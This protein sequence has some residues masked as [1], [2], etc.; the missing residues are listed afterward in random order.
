MRKILLV[1]VTVLS[2]GCG[3]SAVAPSSPVGS[4]IVSADLQPT[5]LERFTKAFQKAI[6]RA[7]GVPEVDGASMPNTAK[8]VVI[9]ATVPQVFRPAG[10]VLAPASQNP[11]TVPA[12][13]SLLAVTL[14]PTLADKLAVG[15]TIDWKIDFSADNGQTWQT[16]GEAIWQ[17][18]GP[19][20]FHAIN[21]STGEHIDN[22]DVPLEVSLLNHR[23]HLI[24]TIITWNH[25]MTFGMTISVT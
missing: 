15:N 24:R 10:T 6:Q 12:T 3:Q 14:T 4:A 2:V 21:L 23:G 20:G 13:A 5:D 8:A 16:S 19:L 18:Y 17:S 1:G 11:L 9:L 25:D 22:P 7:F